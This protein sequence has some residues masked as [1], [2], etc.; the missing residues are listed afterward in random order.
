MDRIA[1]KQTNVVCPVIDIISDD[2]L[3]YTFNNDQVSVGGFDWGLQVFF[4]SSIGFMP[5]FELLP[6]SRNV[7]AATCRGCQQRGSVVHL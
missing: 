2:T 6:P 1:R 5:F 3:E 7:R 4:W